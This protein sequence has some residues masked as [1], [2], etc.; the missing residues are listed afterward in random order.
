[1]SD[2]APALIPT[3][4]LPDSITQEL[5]RHNLTEATIE[6]INKESIELTAVPIPDAKAYDAMKKRR[7]VFR[8]TRV[9][10]ETLFKPWKSDAHEQWKNICTAENK[11]TSAIEA[12]EQRLKDAEKEYVGREERER[13][14]RHEKHKRIVAERKQ[15]LF[16]RGFTFN[17][18][19]FIYEGL[20]EIEEND[21]VGPHVNDLQFGEWLAAIDHD[22]DEKNRLKKEAEDLERERVETL[23]RERKELQD[24][25]DAANE[26]AKGHAFVARKAELGLRNF[27]YDDVEDSFCLGE[28]NHLASDIRD[29]SEE[30]WTALLQRA[31]EEKL[32]IVDREIDEKNKQLEHS[33]RRWLYNLNCTLDDKGWSYHGERIPTP[34]TMPT[35]MCVLALE[36]EAQWAAIMQTAEAIIADVKQR[37]ARQELLTY[38]VAQLLANGW[39]EAARSPI[40]NNPALVLNTGPELA[41]GISIGVE[42]LATME[43]DTFLHYYDEGRTEVTRRAIDQRDKEAAAAEATRQA[44]LDDKGKLLDLLNKLNALDLPKLT[45]ANVLIEKRQHHWYQSWVKNLTEQ[46]DAL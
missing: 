17:G 35:T 38:R 13:N 3:I 5:I 18:K 36:D 26:L 28:I 11:V 34:M 45:P 39:I 21:V 22:I 2:K 10:A 29:M 4:V 30:E 44:N 31:E 6:G 27:Y 37:E 42:S 14:E 15:M 9:L 32:R 16:D 24:Q 8:N 12:A 40:S 46:M 43:E 1:M 41:D 33:R 25:L 7:T 19:S 23:E 20:V